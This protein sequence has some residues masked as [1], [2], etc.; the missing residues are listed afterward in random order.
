[1][2]L[3]INDASDQFSNV[4]LIQ[5]SNHKQKQISK[6]NLKQKNTF[7]EKEEDNNS[8][9]NILNKI[10][11][12]KPKEKKEIGHHK[13]ECNFNI[14]ISKTKKEFSFPNLNIR[15]QSDMTKNNVEKNTH[16]VKYPQRSAF[17]GNKKFKPLYSNNQDL[18]YS[19]H[20]HLSS[21]KS[22]IEP[23]TEVNIFKIV[24]KEKVINFQIVSQKKNNPNNNSGNS[25][26]L[27]TNKIVNINKK[28]INNINENNFDKHKNFDAFIQ[29]EPWPLENICQMKFTINTPKKKKFLCC[30]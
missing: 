5:P 15:R 23:I 21:H 2:Q 11:E 10:L 29:T 17:L 9:E 27:V 26:V 14:K 12:L 28:N 18:N 19:I 8:Y 22:G 13:S 7:K 4:R 20:S 1:M 16:N 3:N 30:F 25:I 24:E 6:N